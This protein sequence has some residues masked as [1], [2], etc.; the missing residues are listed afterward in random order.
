[1]SDKVWTWHGCDLKA[2]SRNILGCG[3]KY[4]IFSTEFEEV[5]FY[6][7]HYKTLI[8]WESYKKSRFLI[9]LDTYR[10][11]VRSKLSAVL[12]FQIWRIFFLLCGWQKGEEEKQQPYVETLHLGD[13]SGCNF[14]LHKIYVPF[15]QLH[16]MIEK[17]ESYQPLDHIH[18]R[19]SARQIWKSKTAD[20]LKRTWWYV[21]LHFFL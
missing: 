19:F 15:Y 12:D 10:S 21:G 1:M 6:S 11:Q 14:D 17:R 13:K 7:F 16:S 9:G 18:G 20:S 2:L 5:T 4:F 3:I 8:V